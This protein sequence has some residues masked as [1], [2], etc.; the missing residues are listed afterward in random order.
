LQN[1]TH[2]SCIHI[3]ARI[4]WIFV[5]ILHTHRDRHISSPC[6]Y[7][8][9]LKSWQL[10]RHVQPVW[11]LFNGNI[12]LPIYLTGVIMWHFDIFLCLML[13]LHQFSENI[14]PSMYPCYQSRNYFITVKMTNTS[15]TWSKLSKVQTEQSR[16]PKISRYLQYVNHRYPHN[17]IKHH[18]WKI[19]K[20][21]PNEHRSASILT[22]VCHCD[23]YLLTFCTKVPFLTIVAVMSYCY[24]DEY[25]TYTFPKS[26][27][28]GTIEVKQIILISIIINIEHKQQL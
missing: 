25:F 6:M 26:K 11:N 9:V 7:A 5:C 15:K 18:T 20:L 23:I 8:I 16:R 1:T 14:S 19:F 4:K 27:T 21:F 2:L 22:K 13:I 17:I 3:A 12:K 10:Y 28:T 24:S